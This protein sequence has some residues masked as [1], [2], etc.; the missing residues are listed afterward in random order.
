[1]DSRYTLK[2]GSENMCIADIMELLSQTHWACNRKKATVEKAIKN[3]LCFG[4]FDENGKQIAFGRAVTDYATMYYVSDVVVDKWHH[5]CGLGTVL[6]NFIKDAP[7]LEKLWGFLGT[8]KAA[9]FY[10][11]FGFEKKGDFFMAMK[12]TNVDGIFNVPNGG[13][14]NEPGEENERHDGLFYDVYSYE[15]DIQDP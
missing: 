7:E 6:M 11:G 12:K 15:N 2:K 8:T 1:M 14:V 13:P 3:S 4:I 10:S 5:H 9:D